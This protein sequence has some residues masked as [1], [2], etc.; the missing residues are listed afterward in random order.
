MEMHP[1][2]GQGSRVA[3]Q[4]ISCQS[5]VDQPL[6]AANPF[7]N[8]EMTLDFSFLS[9]RQSPNKNVMTSY[10]GRSIEEQTHRDARPEEIRSDET[11]EMQQKLD[12]LCSILNNLIERIEL[13]SSMSSSEED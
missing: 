11:K 3:S 5:L 9:Y 6:I 8:F 12:G 13:L 2:L 4:Q 7:K 1:A 10:E